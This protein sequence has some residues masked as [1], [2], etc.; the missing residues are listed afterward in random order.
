MMNDGEECHWWVLKD[1]VRDWCSGRYALGDA[2][3][4]TR[5]PTIASSTAISPRRWPVTVASWC[6]AALMI[7]DR[8]AA[9][10]HRKV[11]WTTA[12]ALAARLGLDALQHPLPA[13]CERGAR[14]PFAP[15][16]QSQGTQVLMP[17]R[18]PVHRPPGWRPP[19]PWQRSAGQQAQR[20][21]PL[22]SG[23]RRLRQ[24][25]LLEKPMC[26]VCRAEGR[27]RPA[28]EVDHILPRSQGGRTERANLQPLCGPCHAAKTQA[29][30]RMGRR[31][32]GS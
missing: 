10:S 17:A 14:R 30:A 19:A 8:L 23:W 1:R 9:D 31:G 20:E 28:Q 6:V 25:V 18:P 12:S 26:R 13:L 21:H 5:L 16:G 7:W 2:P 27:V 3:R 24:L 11:G 29:E 22:P 32:A 15:E 4:P